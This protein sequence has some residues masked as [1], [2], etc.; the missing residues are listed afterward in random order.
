MIMKHL[1]WTICFNIVRGRVVALT[2]RKIAKPTMCPWIAIS[3]VIL[4]QMK[5]VIICLIYR[6]C[7]QIWLVRKGWTKCL[8]YQVLIYH[9]NSKQN[10]NSKHLNKN[11]TYNNS[12]CPIQSIYIIIIRKDLRYWKRLK[13]SKWWLHKIYLVYRIQ[14]LNAEIFPKAR[15]SNLHQ[16]SKLNSQ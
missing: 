16:I 2:L 5:S 7:N 12:L 13:M 3:A 8:C 9:S 4:I 14:F 6:K 11:W 10:Y 1:N 15:L